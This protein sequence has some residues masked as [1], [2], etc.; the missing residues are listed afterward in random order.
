M[1]PVT[2]AKAQRPAVCAL[3]LASSCT[4]SGGDPP[5]DP[6][7]GCAAVTGA[8]TFLVEAKLPID[9]SNR[10]FVRAE[11]CTGERCQR[12]ELDSSVAESLLP[13][14]ALTGAWSSIPEQS[15]YLVAEPSEARWKL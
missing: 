13:G 6:Y 15:T 11:L 1:L 4:P 3:L 9:R 12:A 2:R 10:A 14:K 7:A 8:K 5:S